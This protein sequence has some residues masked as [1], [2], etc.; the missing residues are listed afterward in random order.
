MAGGMEAE[1]DFGSR[2]PFQPEALGAD[3][4]APIRAD[5]DMGAHAPHIGPPSTAWG[6]PHNGTV[7]LPGLVPSPLRGLAQFPMDF[8]G[9]VVRPQLVDMAIGHGDFL[10]F[11]TG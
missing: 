5:L 2:R 4:D 9:V 6:F 3:R 1:H 8:L 11:F 7:F 10:N